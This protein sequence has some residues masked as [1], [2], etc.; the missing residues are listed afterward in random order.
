LIDVKRTSRL[1][2]QVVRINADLL[3]FQSVPSASESSIGVVDLIGAKVAAQAS[4]RNAIT[5]K[6][7]FICHPPIS[8]VSQVSGISFRT[9]CIRRRFL[10]VFAGREFGFVQW[11]IR[12]V[13]AWP[14][15]PLHGIA[16]AIRMLIG[17]I[18]TAIVDVEA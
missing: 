5:S 14:T 18:W 4:A 11:T 6:G 9:R 17:Q 16:M 7:C 15:K 8:A 2:A 3:H 13:A 10:R 1:G 12:F